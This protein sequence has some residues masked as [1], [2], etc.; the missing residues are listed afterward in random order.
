MFTTP[1]RYS[2]SDKKHGHLVPQTEYISFPWAAGNNLDSNDSFYEPKE[3]V[4]GDSSFINGLED[5]I[6]YEEVCSVAATTYHELC[7]QVYNGELVCFDEEEAPLS[8]VEM[9]LDLSQD[10]W[11][12]SIQ[13]D[14]SEI[15]TMPLNDTTDSFY[16]ADTD[17]IVEGI[18]AESKEYS[19]PLNTCY[20]KKQCEPQRVETR[21]Q[22]SFSPSKLK[23]LS[24]N[25]TT[26]ASLKRSTKCNKRMTR[27]HT[28]A[29]KHNKHP[30]SKCRIGILTP[31]RNSLIKYTV[32]LTRGIISPQ[33]KFTATIASPLTRTS[34]ITSSEKNNTL[35]LT[36]I[37]AFIPSP[38]L[39]HH[40]RRQPKHIEMEKLTLL[41]TFKKKILFTK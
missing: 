20:L 17:G 24:Q 34:W 19:T 32:P 33:V 2:L 9:S 6:N 22:I 27:I 31:V 13:F 11:N 36:P 4:K 1:P 3:F 15:D 41:N 7:G 39:M 8:D 38:M 14:F 21:S 18:P 26:R 29:R 16:P 37:D 30:G 40:K 5:N 23:H 25:L 12:D 35:T 10:N 28:T